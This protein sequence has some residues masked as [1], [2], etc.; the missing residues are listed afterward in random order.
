[1]VHLRL[2]RPSTPEHVGLLRP[3]SLEHVRGRSEGVRKFEKR[4]LASVCDQR[5]R[6]LQRTGAVT[7]YVYY[8]RPSSIKGELFELYSASTPRTPA[9]PAASLTLY[10]PCSPPSLPSY[11]FCLPSS[12]HCLPRKLALRATATVGVTLYQGS[13]T[14]D[15][16]SS[17]H[18]D[19][20]YHRGAGTFGGL[21]WNDFPDLLARFWRH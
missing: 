2:R 20:R 1:M 7:P 11:L 13:L 16:I 19:S 3:S 10:L 5:K 6:L 21:R 17:D 18:L 15:L 9:P 12:S 8:L 4:G 14:T